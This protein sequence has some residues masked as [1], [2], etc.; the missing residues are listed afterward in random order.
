MSFPSLLFRICLGIVSVLVLPGAA[1][2]ASEDKPRLG[3]LYSADGRHGDEFDLALKTLDWPAERFVGKPEVLAALPDKLAELDM[4]IVAPLFN[5]KNPVLPGKDREKY[6]KFVENGGM[7]AVTDGS[8]EGVRN[9]LGDI[10]PSFGGL[11]EG[12]CN[13]SQW[14]VL[15][16]TT[17]ADPAHPLRFFPSRI[18]EPNSWPHF[19]ELPKDSKWQVVTKCSEG[20]P[21]TFVQKVGKGYVSL[22]ALRQPSAEHFRNFYACLLLQRA[23]IELASFELPEPA[24]GEGTLRMELGKGSN[25][26]S[27]SFVYE[28]TGA[29]G[30]TERFEKAI[31]GAKFELGYRFSK[32]GPVKTRLLFKKDGRESLLFSRDAEL[33]AL[34]TVK[35]NAYRGIISTKRRVPAVKFGIEL[36]PDEEDLTGANVALSVVDSQ[37]KTVG[38]AEA[39]IAD[40]ETRSLSQAVALDSKLPEGAYKVRAVLADKGGK[41]LAES[42]T[43]LKI[44]APR[45]AQT[46]VDEDRTLLVNGEPFF[47]LGLYHVKQDDYATVAGLGINTIQYWTWDGEKGLEKA[48]AHRLKAI[49][50]LNHKNEEIVR[51][52]VKQYANNPSIL[53]WYGLDEP[54]EASHGLAKVM[55]DTFTAEDDHHPVYMV[56]CRPDIF[57]EQAKFGDVFAHDPYGSPQKALEWMQKSNAAVDHRKAVICVPGSFGKE[58]AAELR[59]T[60]YLALA[61]DARGIMWYPWS[62]TGGGP[63]GVGLKNSPEQQAVIQELCAEIHAL[64]PM[65][66]SP[67][68]TSIQSEDG[69]L[70]GLHSVVGDQSFIL[71][72]NGTDQ[73]IESRVSLPANFGAGRELRDFFRGGGGPLPISGNSFT[74]SLKPYET[75]VYRS[76]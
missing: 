24:M 52:V 9:W 71:L 46:I 33:P 36:A 44:L 60:A 14:A 65:L 61:N 16:A 3:I 67:E 56:S 40:R 43:A 53:M 17:N 74:I 6:L 1:I 49:F 4:L 27:G 12:K 25:S 2:A 66:T 76:E 20:N 18:T 30:K 57:K 29:D 47:P 51:N 8:Y 73:A 72:V 38:S 54:A 28:I 75:R 39:K 45:E 10:S 5:L 19:H 62:Q 31:G 63:V 35:P 48:A 23:G 70:Q 68:R 26:A 41:S 22:S 59:A 15:G 58:T 55:L 64:K 32:R 13:S 42:E 11:A 37:G 50:E 34:L 69:K 21:V 7:I